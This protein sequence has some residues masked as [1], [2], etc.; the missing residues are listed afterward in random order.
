MVWMR[1]IGRAAEDDEGLDQ[2]SSEEANS[3]NAV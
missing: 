2:S 3:S 1:K